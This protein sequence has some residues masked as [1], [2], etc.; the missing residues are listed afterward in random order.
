MNKIKFNNITP[1]FLQ[2]WHDLNEKLPNELIKYNIGY[3]NKPARIDLS[4]DPHDCRE[5]H[6]RA[7]SEDQLDGIFSKISSC[8]SDTKNNYQTK[9]NCYKELVENKK[10]HDIFYNGMLE[11]PLS[12]QKLIND[13]AREISCFVNLKFEINRYT[14]HDNN[15]DNP[16]K[17]ALCHVNN[18]SKTTQKEGMALAIINEAP[19]IRLDGY[20][21]LFDKEA[22]ELYKH[23]NLE[24]NN[25][26]TLKHEIL[27]AIG[28]AHPSYKDFNEQLVYRS[29]MED[30]G[31]EDNLLLNHYF[32]KHKDMVIALNYYQIP[33]QL[34]PVDVKG[35][36][37]IWGESLDNTDICQEIR[38]NSAE[39]YDDYCTFEDTN[40]QHD[41]L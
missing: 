7:L 28:L 9:F 15:P 5:L 38:E 17:I 13:F 4:F 36:L 12:Y 39:E 40:F 2:K 22:F 25:I 29:L 16:L 23:Y 8:N 14:T 6:L 21:A 41:E 24:S 10:V 35:L 27:H 30:V 19:E 1:L 33:T 34:T 20:L 31:S 32:D 11:L 37:T 3:T 18:L 26:N